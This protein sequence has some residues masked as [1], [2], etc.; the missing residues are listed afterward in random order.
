MSRAYI[1]PRRVLF[2]DLLMKLNV[3]NFPWNYST[4]TLFWGSRENSI[5]IA[6]PLKNCGVSQEEVSR[7][8]VG[9]DVY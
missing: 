9:W 2:F 3:S 8:N 4:A 1:I 5:V 7:V 6:N